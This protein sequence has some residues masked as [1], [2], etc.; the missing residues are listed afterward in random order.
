MPVYQLTPFKP[1]PKLLTP[2]I[3]AYFWGSFRDTTGPTVGNVLSTSGNGSTSTVKVQILGGNVPI[4]SALSVPL[5]TIVGSAGATGAYNVTNVAITS[6]SVAT[7]PDSGIYNISFAGSGSSAAAADAGQFI[8]PQPEVAE[9]LVTDAKSAPLVMPYN[10]MSA[11]LNQA[12]TVVASF[13]SIPT[14]IILYLQQALQDLDA[15]YADVNT[16]V[17]VAGGAVTGGGQI[18]VDPTLG[19][20][21][22]VRA[23]DMIGGTLP[24]LIVKMMI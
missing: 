2:G 7:N 18:S 17:T 6:I 19:R 22:R 23:G 10:I 4:V 16:I 12:V 11:N 24:T 1:T 9:T 15:E 14:S 20:F 8:I 21:F 13:P 5:I 3:P